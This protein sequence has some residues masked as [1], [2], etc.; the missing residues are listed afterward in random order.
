MKKA[1]LLLGAAVLLFVALTAGV[2]ARYAFVPLA[3]EP[4]ATV[5][6]PAGAAGRLAGALRIRTIS[7][8][9]PA[10]FD[11]AAFVTLELSGPA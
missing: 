4:A 1:I 8:E 7:A 11:A 9:D 5:T 6:V 2:T 10:A 3:V